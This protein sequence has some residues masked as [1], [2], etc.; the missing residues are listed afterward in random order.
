MQTGIQTFQELIP[1]SIFG[2]RRSQPRCSIKLA[3]VYEIADSD[4]RTG[5]G[6]TTDMSSSGLAFE[7]TDPLQVGDFLEVSIPWPTIRAGGCNTTFC[8]YGR[9]VRYDEGS[10]AVELVRKAFVAAV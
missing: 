5:I 8:A 2:E 1:A 3:L 10:V 9:V 6:Q 7:T 4:G